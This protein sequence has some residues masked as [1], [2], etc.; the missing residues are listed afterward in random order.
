MNKTIDIF[1]DNEVIQMELVDG[2]WVV[3][4]D[5]WYG[6]S[7][8]VDHNFKRKDL[9]KILEKD[10]DEWSQDEDWWGGTHQ[11]DVNVYHIYPNESACNYDGHMYSVTVY[12]LELCEGYLHVDT[13]TEI[14]KFTIYI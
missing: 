8:K 13:D 5:Y 11:W 6:H 4:D 2:D 3:A 14:D 9:I 7:C 12:G 10:F 1:W